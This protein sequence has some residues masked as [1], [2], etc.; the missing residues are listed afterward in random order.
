MTGLWRKSRVFTQMAS[1]AQEETASQPGLFCG[2]RGNDHELREREGAKYC[3]SGGSEP[4]ASGPCRRINRDA[5][6]AAS[7]SG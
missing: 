1:L 4:S 6:T 3:R 7:E 5:S 2:E